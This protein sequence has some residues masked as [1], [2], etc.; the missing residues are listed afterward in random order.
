MNQASAAD[1][2]RRCARW[3]VVLVSVLVFF[4]PASAA[5]QTEVVGGPGGTLFLDRPP[6]GVRVGAVAFGAGAWIDSVT[7]VYETPD[8]RRYR[9]PRHGGATGDPCVIPI[10]PDERILGIRGRYGTFIESVQFITTKGLSRICGGPGGAGNYRIDV[11]PNH[12]FVGFA[13]RAGSYV[14][15]IGLALAPQSAT[16]SPPPAAPNASAPAPAPTKPGSAPASPAPAALTGKVN[17]TRHAYDATLRFRLTSPA[18]VRVLLGPRKLKPRECFAPDERVFAYKDL[19]AA[20]EHTVTFDHLQMNSTYNYLIRIG[21][22][23]CESGDF[24][25]ATTVDHSQ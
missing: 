21:G 24:D 17:I 7:V 11:P 12:T 20:A 13:G 23:I 8:G 10:A 15:A 25:T 9:S 1:V 4:G 5:Q 16:S 2:M 19:P 3:S 18:P 22:T 14:D 6:A